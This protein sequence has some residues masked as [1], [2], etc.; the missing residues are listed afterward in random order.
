MSERNCDFLGRQAEPSL[1]G[2]NIK[3]TEIARWYGKC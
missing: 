1:A 2:K 3:I